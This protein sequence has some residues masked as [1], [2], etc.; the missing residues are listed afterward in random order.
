MAGVVFLDRDGVIN[1]DSSHY[2]KHPSE[3]HFIPGSPEAI[4]LLNRHGFD[5]ILVTNQ[6]IIGRKM[7][8][9]QTLDL[10]FKKMCQGIAAAGGRILDIF[11]CP[12][13]PNA[14]C[15]CRKP[16]PGML[17]HAR[18][19]HKLKLSRSLLV[20]DS[21]KDIQA[22]RNAG[23][24]KAILVGT[25]NGKTAFQNLVCQGSPPDYYAR[26]LMDAAL[27]ITNA[28]KTAP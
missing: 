22:A 5:I 12:H 7:V 24:A 8:T 2:I 14:G 1:Q 9:Q 26:D 23:C 20:G 19:R 28:K 4:A 17:F 18:K 3:F 6:S 11:F 15:D 10:I 21:V 13:A 27:W 25:G 16:A